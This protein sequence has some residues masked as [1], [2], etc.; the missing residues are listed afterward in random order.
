V[1]NCPSFCYGTDTHHD[2]GGSTDA[3][4]SDS[5][6]TGGTLLAI[7]AGN[8]RPRHI[9]VMGQTLY[10]TNPQAGLVETVNVN[11]GQSANLQGSQRQPAG[12]ISTGGSIIWAENGGGPGNVVQCAQP[13][14]CNP[15]PF[16]TARN[17][18][19]LVVMG[20]QGN[21]LVFWTEAAND[22]AWC[23]L[24]GGCVGGP[25]VMHT[26]GGPI[27]AI[28]SIQNA[29][30]FTASGD[31]HVLSCPQSG[32][33]GSP[34]QVTS[35]PSIPRA[36]ATDG[37]L[38]VISTGGSIATCLPTNCYNPNVVATNLGDVLGVV[39]NGN[40]IF[41]ADRGAGTIGH[42]LANNPPP[43]PQLLATNIPIGPVALTTD[44]NY[45]YFVTDDGKVM[46]VSTS[47]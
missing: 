26:L 4:G 40:D 30:Y 6:V 43:Q 46:K 1:S 44:P 22:I 27:T 35:F 37:A 20:L 28:V 17:T 24:G 13:G 41:Y 36:L 16:A 8:G 2:T 42:T 31:N 19:D 15:T 29:V 33:S 47:H 23:P 21:N 38:L 9:V 5:S 12:I 14:P 3:G 7:A 39:I 45:V 34:T 18:P 32:C 11:G 10:W 25:T